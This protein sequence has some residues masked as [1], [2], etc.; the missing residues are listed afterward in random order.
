MLDPALAI[1]LAILTGAMAYLG[2]H[3]TVH[4]PGT[5]RAKTRYKAAFVGLALGSVLVIGIQSKR[6]ADS[7]AQLEATL[8]GIKMQSERPIEANVRIPPISLIVPS[9]I[10]PDLPGKVDDPLRLWFI[11][12]D[13]RFLFGQDGMRTKSALVSIY[14]S[15]AVANPTLDI[16]CEVALPLGCELDASIGAADQNTTYLTGHEPRIT[17]RNQTIG[18]NQPLHVRIAARQREGS[19]HLEYLVKHVTL[20]FLG[21]QSPDWPMSRASSRQPTPR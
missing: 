14:T 19:E 5:A 21:V 1:G 4:P 20:P 16:Q 18:P 13:A 10:Q 8:Q 12:K 3:M 2:V 6:S 15:R 17:L 7:Q 11:E 9:P